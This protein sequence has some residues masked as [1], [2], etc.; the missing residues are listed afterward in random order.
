MA[1]NK[2]RGWAGTA[3]I[4]LA[5]VASPL[6]D[7]DVARADEASDAQAVI[8]DQL[9][10]FSRDDWTEAFTFASPL[11]KEMFGTPER[12]GQM[13][14]GGY[15]MVWRP[16]TVQFVETTGEP[17]R[18]IQRVLFTDLEGRIWVAR[19]EMIQLSGGAWRING[20]SIE[21]QAG[22]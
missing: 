22:A 4:A 21:E 2:L 13:V 6:T 10:A 9:E 5:L 1:K 18:L 15:P 19:Y 16:A 3:A 20:V 14:R 11:I 7:A 8:S 17:P 12:F